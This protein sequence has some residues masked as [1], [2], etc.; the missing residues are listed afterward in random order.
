M[1]L[2]AGES[3][4]VNQPPVPSQDAPAPVRQLDQVKASEAPKPPAPVVSDQ[5]VEVPKQFTENAGALSAPAPAEKSEAAQP[6]AYYAPAPAEKKPAGATTTGVP[7]TVSIDKKTGA[8][9]YSIKGLDVLTT[10]KSGKP[11]IPFFDKK[12][13]GV[14]VQRFNPAPRT[15]VIQWVVGKGD[16]AIQVNAVFSGGENFFSG[17][18]GLK[19]LTGFYF[20]EGEIEEFKDGKDFVATGG[21]DLGEIKVKDGKIILEKLPAKDKKKEISSEDALKDAQPVAFRAPAPVEKPV[22]GYTF[23]QGE[24]VRKDGN[25]LLMRGTVVLKLDKDGKVII[26]PDAK[27]TLSKPPKKFEGMYWQ[28]D[29]P[30]K[31]EVH[32]NYVDGKMEGIMFFLRIKP[33]L[34][35]NLGTLEVDPKGKVKF[36]PAL[37]APAGL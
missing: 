23:E 12:F 25:N 20:L 4:A 13:N 5:N 6:V 22:A 21:D 14:D 8:T 16:K 9:T 26:P 10:E 15:Y 30:A 32:V 1:A 24:P 37:A 29:K 17:S 27:G 31:I 11:V 3:T 19:G 35:E 36:G 7:V 28:T 2:Q 34:A 33:G 18:E